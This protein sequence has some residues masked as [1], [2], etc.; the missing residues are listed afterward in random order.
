[1]KAEFVDAMTRRVNCSTQASLLLLLLQLHVA[2]IKPISGRRAF[3]AQTAAATAASRRLHWEQALAPTNL[4][5]GIQVANFSSIPRPADITPGQY[6]FNFEE[7]QIE[8]TVGFA[9]LADSPAES[10]LYGTYPLGP[11]QVE[12]LAQAISADL[13]C[14]ARPNNCNIHLTFAS[15]TGLPVD[16]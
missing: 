12:Q 3:H 4:Q 6:W 15:I 14:L 9:G 16:Y 7:V 13:V 1:M 2:S 11:S 5:L 10:T 8:G